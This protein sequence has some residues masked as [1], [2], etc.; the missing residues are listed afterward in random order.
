MQGTKIH[1]H[2]DEN[3]FVEIKKL[4]INEKKGKI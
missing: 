2:A 4:I 1:S 3:D